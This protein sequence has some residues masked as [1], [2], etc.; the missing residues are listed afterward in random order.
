METIARGNSPGGPFE[1]CPF[2]PILTQRSTSNPIQ[3][4]G[5]ADLIEAADGSWWLV[6]LGIRPNGLPRVHHLGRET[7]LAPVSWDSSGWPHV[8]EAGRI[9]LEMDAPRLSPVT[10]EPAADRDDFD[11]L[12][13][14]MQWNF[15]GN[16]DSAS[17]SLAERPGWLRLMG[18]ATRLDDG[19]G[20]TFVGRRQEHFNCEAAAALDYDPALDGEEAGLTVWMN[21]RHHY[22][23]FVSRVGGERRIGVRGRIGG[24]SALMAQQPLADEP[25][26]LLVRA[27]RYTYEFAFTQQG[28]DE[29]VLAT[30]ETRYLATEVAGG[31][32]GVY[33]GLYAGG[34]GDHLEGTGSTPAFFDWFTYRGMDQQSG[35]GVE[36]TV[37]ELLADGAARAVLERHLPGFSPG[38]VPDFTAHMPLLDLAAMAPEQFPRAKIRAIRNDLR[39]LSEQD[40][41]SH[42]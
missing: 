7:F 28:S 30:L 36:S 9:A 16:P 6:C 34:G 37:R 5:H 22:D 29:R 4:T 42:Q 39:R 19:A 31:F 17:W 38:A 8:G 1:G 41:Q 11:A 14:Q 20:V 23:L 15:I 21:P 27:D 24:I 13:L 40:Q 26:T 18:S 12:Q 3:A 10:W 2:N 25:L 32:T 35:L 33:F